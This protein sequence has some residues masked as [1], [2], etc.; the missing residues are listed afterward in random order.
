MSR[1][2][3]GAGRIGR[4]WGTKS[5][6]Y[7][8]S[9]AWLAARLVRR[10]FVCLL[11]AR[12]VRWRIC[13][14]VWAGSKEVGLGSGIVSVGVIWVRSGLGSP[15]GV[16]GGGSDACRVLGFLGWV[17]FSNSF[18]FCPGGVARGKGPS[19]VLVVSPP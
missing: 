9:V 7:W 17:A 2:G 10:R 16:V 3:F 12:V 18:A 14:L 5:G 6:Q 1:M 19:E 15:S 11:S 8:V 4:L 13:V